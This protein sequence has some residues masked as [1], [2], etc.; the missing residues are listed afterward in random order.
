MLAYN[1]FYHNTL[2][3]TVQFDNTYS[4]D[5]VIDI[6]I[7]E[8]YPPGIIITELKQSDKIKR[9]MEEYYDID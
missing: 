5:D 3:D 7:T 1:V 8:G 2:I 9:K 4:K 6:L